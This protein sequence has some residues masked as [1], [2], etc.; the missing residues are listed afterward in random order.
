MNK[1]AQW[2]RQNIRSGPDG[3]VYGQCREAIE[4]M[5]AASPELVRVRDYYYLPLWG[6]RAHWW[7]YDPDGRSS[8]SKPG[9][10]GSDAPPAPPAAPSTLAPT[11]VPTVATVVPAPAPVPPAP[12]PAPAKPV[13]P[14]AKASLKTTPVPRMKL[15]HCSPRR[16]RLLWWLQ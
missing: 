16:P 9:A 5:A 12:L 8:A 2:I 3:N 7:L 15:R 14:A 11:V 10:P 13:P 4:R 1:Y 6:G